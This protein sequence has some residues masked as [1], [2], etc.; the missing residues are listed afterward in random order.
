MY[1]LSI[2]ISIMDTVTVP[3][4]INISLLKK[5][6]RIF[7]DNPV[8][9]RTMKYFIED[10]ISDYIEAKNDE[11]LRKD[12]ENDSEIPELLSHIDSVLWIS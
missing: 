8:M 2:N 11:Q 10:Y 5:D 6:K 4:Q 12:I 3:I 7:Q 1:C 9:L